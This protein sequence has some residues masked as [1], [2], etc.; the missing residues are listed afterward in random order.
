[1]AVASL[2]KVAL[3]KTADS[4]PGFGTFLSVLVVSLFVLVFGVIVWRRSAQGL[5]TQEMRDFPKYK[6]VLISLCDT[7]AGI[8]LLVPADKV[9]GHLVT[10]LL[11]AAVTFTMIVYILLLHK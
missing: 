4:L 9:D 1:M 11:Q 6:F 10:L 2:E 8:L 3:K 5:I 7:A